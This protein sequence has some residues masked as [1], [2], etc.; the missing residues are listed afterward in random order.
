MT[1]K[2]QS[3]MVMLPSSWSVGAMNKFHSDFDV[4]VNKKNIYRLE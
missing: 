3:K 4:A 1:E 2:P